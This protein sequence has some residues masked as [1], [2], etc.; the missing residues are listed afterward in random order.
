MREKHI[1]MINTSKVTLGRWISCKY[2]Y[3]NVKPRLGD[4]YS[5][6]LCSEC[7]YGLACTPG[8]HRVAKRNV[9]AAILSIARAIPGLVRDLQKAALRFEQEFVLRREWLRL[10]QQSPDLIQRVMHSAPSFTLFRCRHYNVRD[11]HANRR[12][13][14]ERVHQL[15]FKRAVRA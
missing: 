13:A 6:V 9:L 12:Q 5:I 4:D 3:K 7:G 15:G 10:L 11:L 8:L 2:C 1:A 14:V